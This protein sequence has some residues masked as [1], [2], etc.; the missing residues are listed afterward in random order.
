MEGQI[1]LHFTIG[2]IKFW[3]PMISALIILG[4]LTTYQKIRYLIRIS[5]LIAENN[6]QW[7][8]DESQI[9]N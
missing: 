4:I 5:L 1:V 7:S 8:P 6:T 9:P 3:V 2:K